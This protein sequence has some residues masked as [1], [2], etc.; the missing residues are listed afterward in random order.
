LLVSVLQQLVLL[1]VDAD[2]GKRLKRQSVSAERS[3]LKKQTVAAIKLSKVFLLILFMGLFSAC[4]SEGISWQFYRIAALD[5]AQKRN[6][7]IFLHFNQSK[8]CQKQ[9]DALQEIV[10]DKLFAEAVAYRVEFGRE[11]ALQKKYS[12]SKPCSLVVLKGSSLKARSV[13]LSDSAGLLKQLKR[14][15]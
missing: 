7:T 4:A 6:M 11:L 3:Q 15:L 13:S 2:V 5:E 1:T 9:Y 10:K 8:T 12:I 14:G